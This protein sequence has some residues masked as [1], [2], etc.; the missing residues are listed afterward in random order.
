MSADPSPA[1]EAPRPRVVITGAGAICA[2]GPT[3]RAIWDAMAEGT[4]AFGPIT[5]FDASAFATRIAAEV[6]NADRPDPRF[7]AAYWGRLDAR[8]RFAVRATLDA[9]RR[10]GLN[11]TPGNRAQVAV[12]LATERPA[13]EAIAAGAARLGAGD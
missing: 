11:L 7:E 1:D 8:S 10:A 4:S 6:A 3:P 5:R 13:D 12:V 9:V 2:L